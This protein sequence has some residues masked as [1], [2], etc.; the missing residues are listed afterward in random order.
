MPSINDYKGK[1]N[2]K[3]AKAQEEKSETV[4]PARAAKR[5]GREAPEFAGEVKVVRME[6]DDIKKENTE[7]AKATEETAT[8]TEPKVEI[9]FFG[10]EVLRSKFPKP[11]EV[12]ESAASSWMNDG[13]FKNVKIGSPLADALAQKGLQK[14]KETEKKILTSPV[15]EKVAM[16]ALTTAMKAQGF[17]QQLKAKFLKK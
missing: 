4:A 5:P 16:Q 1:N 17:A 7:T 2:K 8:A 6:S 15:T 14:A 12:A 10:S 3:L 9:S 11:F 13:D